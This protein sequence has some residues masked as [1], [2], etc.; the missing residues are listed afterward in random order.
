MSKTRRYNDKYQQ[1][2][3]HRAGGRPRR[4][5]SARS[6]RRDAPD[7]RRMGKALIAFTVAESETSAT[8]SRGATPPSTTRKESTDGR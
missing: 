4:K 2:D 7:L 3:D 5:L 8:Q 6:V 1:R